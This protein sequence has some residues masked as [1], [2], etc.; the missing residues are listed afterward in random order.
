[1]ELQFFLSSL[2]ADVGTIGDFQQITN[3]SIPRPLDIP[4][5]PRR[6]NYVLVQAEG[7]NVRYRDD[8]P[9]PTAG[10]GLLLYAGDQPTR[11]AGAIQLLKFIE[12]TAGA[13]LN[14]RYY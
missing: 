5:S 4:P 11:F 13:K 12:A 9:T 7:Q 14:V 8:G 2:V 1:M 10:I 3:L 6:V